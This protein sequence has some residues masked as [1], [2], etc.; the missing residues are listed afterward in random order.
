MHTNIYLLI[1]IGVL[2][3]FLARPL[4]MFV[5]GKVV[6]LEKYIRRKM[7]VVLLIFHR[8]AVHLNLH[9]I[10]DLCIA[11]SIRFYP[12]RA[13]CAS[14]CRVILYWRRTLGDLC[15][16]VQSWVQHRSVR[17]ILWHGCME[18]VRPEVE[19]LAWVMEELELHREQ[20]SSFRGCQIRKQKCVILTIWHHFLDRMRIIGP[21]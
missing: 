19:L 11:E 6:S 3:G 20:Q 14:L 21:E 4:N 5:F 17:N 10:H 15:Q 16:A 13:A 9:D 2:A 12:A 8:H 1:A 18:E 7:L